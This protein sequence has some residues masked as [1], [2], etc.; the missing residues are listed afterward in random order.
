M[1]KE[2][3]VELSFESS[4]SSRRCSQM[5]EEGAVGKGSSLT[6]GKIVR[7]V[8]EA[9]Y[10]IKSDNLKCLFIKSNSNKLIAC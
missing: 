10:S 6:D 3:A 7:Y 8:Y 5:R 4:G 1:R 2:V 9:I